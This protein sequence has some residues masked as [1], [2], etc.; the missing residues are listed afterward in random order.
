MATQ[1]SLV[2]TGEGGL[3]GAAL[4]LTG[5]GFVVVGASLFADKDLVPTDVPAAGFLMLALLAVG[6]V[7]GAGFKR[8][9]P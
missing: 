5:Y 1:H 8:V 6:A 3:A 2:T 7:L 9:R 4:V